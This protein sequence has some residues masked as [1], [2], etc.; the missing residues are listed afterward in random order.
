MAYIYNRSP[1]TLFIWQSNSLIP[2]CAKAVILSSM[3]P[4][5]NVLSQNQIKQHVS[6]ITL[7]II[8]I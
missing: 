5:A 4:Y 1:E 3:S 7:S 2:Q 6:F 8:L